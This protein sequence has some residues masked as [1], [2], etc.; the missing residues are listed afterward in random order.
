MSQSRQLAA[1]MFTDIVG[2]TALMGNDEKKAFE[3][4]N[5]NRSLQ[6][7][8][9]EKNKG[10]WIKEMGDG[11]M[12]SFNTASDAVNAAMQIQEACNAA[13]HFKLKIGIHLGEVVFENDDVY[14]DG[15]NIASRIETL[16][17]GSSVLLS[18]SIRDQVK[19][20]ADLQIASLGSFEFKN[21]E[22][23]VEIF[24]ISN[25]GFVVPKREAMQGKL[26]KIK[27]NNRKPV[28]IISA[29]AIF[30]TTAILL[31][32]KIFFTKNSSADPR[33]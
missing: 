21:V 8:I 7:P 5:Q 17:V 3:L 1:I 6:K 11:V 9:I 13:N 26:K 16:G 15:V 25:P 28:V 24:A 31:A 14:G 22:E 32:K 29:A 30:L 18:K 33:S 27:A 10:R 19:N 12:A 4:L 2:Y 23:P 20:N